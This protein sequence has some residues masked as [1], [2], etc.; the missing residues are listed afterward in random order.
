MLQRCNTAK[1]FC[2]VRQHNEDK[3][4]WVHATDASKKLTVHGMKIPSDLVTGSNSSVNLS[5][6]GSYTV[7]GQ[8]ADI[9]VEQHTRSHWVK[10]CIQ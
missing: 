6:G 2:S 10:G 8:T 1:Q 9:L 3:G 5:S 7:T 4:V